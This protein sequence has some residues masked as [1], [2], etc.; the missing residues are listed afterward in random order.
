MCDRLINS[1]IMSSEEH[2]KMSSMYNE[3]SQIGDKRILPTTLVTRTTFF[4]TPIG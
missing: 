1:A 3:S 2:R 4:M